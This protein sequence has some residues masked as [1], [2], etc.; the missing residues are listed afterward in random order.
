MIL[1]FNEFKN[2]RPLPSFQVYCEMGL[3]K[4]LECNTLVVDVDPICSL[5][6]DYLYADILNQCYSFWLVK[7]DASMN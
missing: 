2:W 7:E 4:V 6:M 3:S 1:P 5:D